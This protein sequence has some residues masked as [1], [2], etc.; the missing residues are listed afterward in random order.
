MWE[1]MWAVLH[2]KNSLRSRL[3]SVERKHFA[4]FWTGVVSEVVHDQQLYVQAAWKKS[5]A[6]CHAS[7]PF[8]WCHTSASHLWS[9]SDLVLN[10]SKPETSVQKAFGAL[11]HVTIT[12]LLWV[13]WGKSQP[14]SRCATPSLC[15][16]CMKLPPSQLRINSVL[17]YYTHSQEPFWSTIK[18]SI[19]TDQLCKFNPKGIILCL[20]SNFVLSTI[21]FL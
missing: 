14:G 15:N 9:E 2:E 5:L 3:L 12:H 21:I 4:L 1:L 16:R 20:R 7:S 13:Q 17:Q 19:K 6:W 8:S 11:S 10:L 18:S